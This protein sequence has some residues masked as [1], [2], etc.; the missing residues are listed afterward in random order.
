MADVDPQFTSMRISPLQ[1]KL[2]AKNPR[3]LAMQ[4]TQEN[5]R[6]YLLTYAKVR[7]LAKQI[8]TAGGLYPGERIVVYKDDEDEY[9][10]LEGNRRVCA[11]QMLLDP[12]RIPQSFR[13]GFTSINEVTRTAISEVFVDFVLSRG[14]ADQFLAARHI[15]GIE[16][17]D[18]LAKKKFFEEKFAL[19][20]TIEEIAS[21]NNYPKSEI[22]QDIIEYYLFHTA[23]SLPCWTDSQKNNELNLFTIDLIRF[24]RIF[25]TKG[26]KKAFKLKAN[27]TSL[28]PESDLSGDKFARIIKQIM[29][30]A[31]IA[32]DPA[33][34]ID[35][36]TKSWKDVPGL[37]AILDE[38][39]QSTDSSQSVSTP[40]NPIAA[41]E[42]TISDQ[43][44]I[45]TSDE[46]TTATP[47]ITPISDEPVQ[48]L[49]LNSTA[50][51]TLTTMT[52]SD[53]PL[54]PTLTAPNQFE[55]TSLT[56]PTVSVMAGPQLVPTHVP[57]IQVEQSPVPNNFFEA[58]SWTA[59][60]NIP[61][62]QGLIAVAEE[63]RKFSQK[64]SRGAAPYELYP[65]AATT[66]LRVIVEQAFKYHLKKKDS[67]AFSRLLQ[68]N[69]GTDPALG[70][71]IKYYRQNSTY[72][73]LITDPQMQRVFVNLFGEAGN[74]TSSVEE[75]LNLTIHQPTHVR[76]NAHILEGRGTDGLFSFVNYILTTP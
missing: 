29:Y 74:T 61:E 73:A 68:S 10:V 64:P 25:G 3:F 47:V 20:H 63:L 24:I 38:P 40:P 70:G 37:L 4:P 55:A 69:R 36:R 28:K 17:W 26:A 43:P 44:A 42:I 18:P 30:C 39:E 52:A 31:Y 22:K 14:A 41:P 56:T 72:K 21:A 34:K 67:Q 62:N 11:C 60:P 8:V 57:Y 33:E 32:T 49:A 23:Y 27:N 5:A 35:T 6:N 7:E 54:Q 51:A 53:V 13:V 1:M 15:G 9:I 59:V 66:L 45:S 16:R 2:D 12:E 75:F 50:A 48:S 76:P 19:G 65:I 58:L 71:I 46:S